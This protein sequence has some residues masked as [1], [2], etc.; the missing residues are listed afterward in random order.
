MDLKNFLRGMETKF[1]EFD[2]ES[3]EASKTSLEGWKPRVALR[4]GPRGT[5]LKNFLRGMETFGGFLGF[6]LG[7]LPQKLP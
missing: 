5:F 1:S 7:Q 6:E 3:G 2:S 4:Y